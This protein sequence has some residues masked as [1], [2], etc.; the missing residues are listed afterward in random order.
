LLGA[1]HPASV[2]EAEGKGQ[3]RGGEE[4]EGGKERGTWERGRRFGET[5]F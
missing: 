2:K 4:K 1:R 5:P 3:R